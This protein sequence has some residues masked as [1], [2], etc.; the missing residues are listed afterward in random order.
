MAHMRADWLHHPLPSRGPPSPH[1]TGVGGINTCTH[2]GRLATSPLQ[3]RRVARLESGGQNQLC[4]P[5]L[6]SEGQNQQRPTCGQIRF[7]SSLP[8]RGFPMLHSGVQN[9]QWPACGQ[10]GYITLAVRGVPNTSQRGG[11]LVVAYMW[12][13]SLHH[14]CHLPYG[15][16]RTVHSGGQNQQ[17]PTCMQI[18]YHLWHLGGPQCFKAGDKISNGPH[19]GRLATSPLAV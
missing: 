8:S 19:E 11:K 4:S 18:G 16:F 13:D 14:H 17:W 3:Y 2:V 6:Q 9:Q 5:T 1:S 10:M 15:G 12:A 7:S